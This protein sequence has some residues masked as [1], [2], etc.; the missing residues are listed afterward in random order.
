MLPSPQY[1][2][3]SNNERERE[4]ESV[5]VCSLIIRR[6]IVTHPG[7]QSVPGPVWCVAAAGSPRCCRWC[8]RWDVSLPFPP[9]PSADN[10]FAIPEPSCT[11]TRLHCNDTQNTTLTM[12]MCR[13]EV[14]DEPCY[15]AWDAVLAL[16][17]PRTP[18][19]AA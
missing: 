9:P 18:D 6:L 10:R 12:C 14:D 3:I 4:R 19:P 16:S 5:C 8:L 1:N 7:F 17:V 15:F 13:G 11:A 2:F